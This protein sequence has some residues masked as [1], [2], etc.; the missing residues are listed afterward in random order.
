MN[1]TTTE[2]KE[3]NPE[4]IKIISS[5]VKDLEKP[6][7][8]KIALL[9]SLVYESRKFD[10]IP[11]VTVND[12]QKNSTKKS[13]NKDKRSGFIVTRNGISTTYKKG[14]NGLD[15]HMSE[16][17]RSFMNDEDK[18]FGLDRDGGREFFHKHM[19]KFA[20]GKHEGRYRPENTFNCNKSEV[21]ELKNVGGFYTT[22]TSTKRKME[23]IISMCEDKGYGLEMIYSN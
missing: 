19:G 20:Q 23:F 11:N 6:Y 10:D 16:V 1:S 18:I 17:F 22:S 14:Y 8:D 9:Q 21:R 4:L 2:I 5:Y 3:L 7:V 13:I 12:F 15:N